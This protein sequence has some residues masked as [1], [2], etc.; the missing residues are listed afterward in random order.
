MRVVAATPAMEGDGVPI[1]RLFPG[2][3]MDSIDPFLLLDEM[4]PLE[5]PAGSEAGFPDHPHRGFETVTY[6]LEGEMEHRDSR[7]HHGIIAAGDVQWMT[8]GAGLVHSEMPGSELRRKGGRLHGFQLWVNLPRRDK[9]T[10]PQYQELPGA[11]IPVVSSGG[12]TVRI[13]AGE[14]LGGQALIQTRTPIAYLHFTLAPGSAYEQAVP[15]GWNAFAYVIDGA[16][17][18]G[19]ASGPVTAG[20]AAILARDG[21]SV[22]L[23]NHST[24]PASALLIAGEPLGEP[25]AQYGP[26]VMNTREEILQAVEDF[27]SGRMG[28]IVR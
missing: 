3:G 5:L 7:G 16:V 20:H 26:F 15:H 11:R 22:K 17:D 6:V 14:S 27:R 19:S 9:M 8:A 4:G 12:V 28:T 13:I 18:L 23:E 25:V 2:R 21:E 1:R 24:T 10:E